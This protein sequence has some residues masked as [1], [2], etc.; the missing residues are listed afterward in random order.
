LL[1][2]YRIKKLKKKRDVDNE[3]ERN[4]N[5]NFTLEIAIPSLN[6]SVNISVLDIFKSAAKNAKFIF[7]KTLVE[8][9]KQIFIL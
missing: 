2:E 1:N 7:P 3:L 8:R 5:I 6:I 9:F 4:E